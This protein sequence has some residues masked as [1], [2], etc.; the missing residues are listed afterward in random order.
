MFPSLLS[1]GWRRLSR[2]CRAPNVSAAKHGEKCEETALCQG[3]FRH[4]CKNLNCNTHYQSLWRDS[5][6]R[7]SRCSHVTFGQIKSQEAGETHRRHTGVEVRRR[8]TEELVHVWRT[9]WRRSKVFREILNVM[10]KHKQAATHAFVKQ[11]IKVTS[12]SSPVTVVTDVPMTGSTLWYTCWGPKIIRWT[13][14][15]RHTRVW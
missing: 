1:E 7:K 11:L 10:F 9:E 2:S 15:K 13:K 14:K 6:V 4:I 8:V 5:S 3:R 12:I